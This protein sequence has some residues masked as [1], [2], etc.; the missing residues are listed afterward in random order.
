MVAEKG[1]Y[2]HQIKTLSWTLKRGKKKIRQFVDKFIYPW[3][4]G[5]RVNY[6]F[7]ATNYV[8]FF[9]AYEHRIR[10]S[11]R[12]EGIRDIE[13]RVKFRHGRRGNYKSSDSYFNMSWTHSMERILIDFQRCCWRLINL[14][15]IS[16]FDIF[17][18][19]KLMHQGVNT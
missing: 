9:F 8:F 3:I 1:I 16:I 13:L 19:Y 15:L 7:V 10:N 14:A 2:S 12:L 18:R 5:I 6:R 17:T 4:I 11:C